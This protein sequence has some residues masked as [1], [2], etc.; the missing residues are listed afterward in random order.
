MAVPR[1]FVPSWRCEMSGPESSDVVV[2]LRRQIYRGV[3]IK[4]QSG[5]TKKGEAY[6]YVVAEWRLG[7]GPTSRVYAAACLPTAWARARALS[8]DAGIPINAVGS[9]AA[10]EFG[11]S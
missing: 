9:A 8:R 10:Y 6:A 3:I 11:A 4:P 1:D 5:T 2:K 7:I